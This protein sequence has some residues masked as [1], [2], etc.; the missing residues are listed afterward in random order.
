MSRYFEIPLVPGRQRF[1]TTILGVDYNFSLAFA[2]CPGGGWFLSIADANSVPIINGLPLVTGADLLA[3]HRALELGFGLW[4]G[5][6][7]APQQP[8]TY[9][10]LGTTG[11][12]YA[13]T[14]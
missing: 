5:T 3:Q 14:P 13:V 9:A 8:P 12:L 11:H 2:N 10:S 7:G 6:D 1:R 4:V